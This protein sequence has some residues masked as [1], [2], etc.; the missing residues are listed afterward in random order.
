MKRLIIITG[1]MLLSVSALA[2]QFA[3][4]G[5]VSSSKV[6]QI[7]N[8]EISGGLNFTQR[9]M[10]SGTITL[11][12]PFLNDPT[13]VRGLDI[14]VAPGS[15]RAGHLQY[16]SG[17]LL[18]DHVEISGTGGGGTGLTN[19]ALSVQAVLSSSR[20]YRNTAAMV[21]HTM[22]P[23][24]GAEHS[25][26]T[27]AT[28]V[29]LKP[30]NGSTQFRNI[31]TGDITTAGYSVQVKRGQC[32]FSSF[33]S[34]IVDYWCTVGTTIAQW[35]QEFVAALTISPSTSFTFPD[36]PIGSTAFKNI[37]STNTGN[38]TATSFTQGITG[39]AGRFRVDSTTC[40]SSLNA[41]ASCYTRFAFDSMSTASK[42]A[43]A[44]FSATGIGPYDVALSGTGTAADTYSDILLWWRA[45]SV[46]AGT[47]DY[48]ASAV[49]YP[50]QSSATL[51][52]T[53]AKVG[54]YGLYSLD[55]YD[56]TETTTTNATY[57]SPVEG[58]F[59]T[60]IYITSMPSGSESGL[61]HWGTS[62]GYVEVRLN[63]DGTVK[64]LYNSGGGTSFSPVSSALSLNTWYYV[65]GS[66][67]T[68]TN[69]YGIAVNGTHTTQTA[70]R[71]AFDANLSGVLQFGNFRSTVA[72]VYMDN[73]A[74]SNLS[75]RSLYALR[76]LTASPR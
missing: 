16:S 2:F 23:A 64:L 29:G 3:G 36:T 28:T 12:P 74:I 20:N 21:K 1:I 10:S 9:Q 66:W 19:K 55:G 43:T 73:I 41:S 51:S 32:E 59:G 44:R 42:S 47:G 27:N 17:K 67:N 76:D 6:R 68:A 54:S 63:T 52:G 33:V 14:T 65:E 4:S 70:T 61:F 13:G 11:L 22:F 5:G 45:E 46:A 31:Q 8:E 69:T 56:S 30:L 7:V 48:P 34:N 50:L 40:G 37:S 75:T 57:V 71:A 62:S 26:F 58:R 72:T 38:A 35:A 53:A 24:T 49:S 18:V 25:K 15:N 60:Y 39:T